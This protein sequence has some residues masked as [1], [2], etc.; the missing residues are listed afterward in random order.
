MRREV[1]VVAREDNEACIAAV[2]K[3]FSR[4]MAYLPRTQ[5]FSLAALNEFYFGDPDIV[6]D[7]KMCVNILDGISSAKQLGDPFTK[8]LPHEKHWD[9]FS[10]CGL[11]P[12]PLPRADMS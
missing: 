1:R 10:R 5:K 4:K 8:P 6:S 9:M 11:F 2:R 12:V 7:E 3:G